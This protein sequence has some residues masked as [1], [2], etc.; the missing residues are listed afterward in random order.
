MIRPLREYH[1]F[2][3]RVL[4][5]VLPASFCLTILL[6][7]D[8]SSKYNRS[9]AQDFSF[10]VTKLQN[11]KGRLTIELK[12]SLRIPSCAVY[13]A[14]PGQNSL[15]GKINDIGT[16]HFDIPLDGEAATVRLYDPIHKKEI[17]ETR[18]FYNNK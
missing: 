6:R 7:P 15:L 17:A 4:A 3:W 2:A 12:N 5:V 13:L 9:N 11:K 10:E 16:Y 18:V 1:F 14:L 8:Y